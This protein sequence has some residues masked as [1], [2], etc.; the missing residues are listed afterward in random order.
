MFMRDFGHILILS[1][2][3]LFSLNTIIREVNIF[4]YDF[5]VSPY[6]VV[7]ICR[8]KRQNTMDVS[9]CLDVKTRSNLFFPDGW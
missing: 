7:S 3:I 9:Q 1:K 6:K 4:S 5:S 8:N 2:L